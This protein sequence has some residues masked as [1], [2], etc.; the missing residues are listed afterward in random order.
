MQQAISQQPSEQESKKQPP[1]QPATAS[2]R[3]TSQQLYR[4]AAKLDQITTSHAS[5]QIQQR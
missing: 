3:T 1:K 2:Q 5:Y 4:N